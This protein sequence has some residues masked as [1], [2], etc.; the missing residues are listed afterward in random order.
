M[1]R[2]DGA[3][4]DDEV[5][6]NSDVLAGPPLEHHL[7]EV[8]LGKASLDAGSPLLVHHR[9]VEWVGRVHGELGIKLGSERLLILVVNAS[10]VGRLD[11][12]MPLCNLLGRD[13]G[14]EEDEL[15][16]VLGGRRLLDGGW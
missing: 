16:R 12:G 14:E 8:D 7:L 11:E 15:V 13:T 10:V 9:V 6:S 1:L 2:G 5:R 4:R 3:K